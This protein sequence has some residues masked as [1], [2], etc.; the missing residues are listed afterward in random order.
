MGTLRIDFWFPDSD[1]DLQRL[2]SLAGHPEDAGK[3]CLDDGHVAVVLDGTVAAP[4]WRLDHDPTYT[5]YDF[6]GATVIELQTAARQLRE[7]APSARVIFLDSP[8]SIEFFREGDSVAVDVVFEFG[9]DSK[10]TSIGKTQIRLEDLQAAADDAVRRYNGRLRD[11]DPRLPGI[12][13]L[14]TTSE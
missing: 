8:V 2:K 4:P 14:Q 13:G 11:V 10:P 12:C 3:R 6:V 5:G 9:P 1:Q 7:G